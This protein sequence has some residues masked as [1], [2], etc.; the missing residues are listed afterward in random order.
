MVHYFLLGSIRDQN[1]FWIPPR[2]V[3]AKTTKEMEGNVVQAVKQL[4]HVLHLNPSNTYVNLLIGE[5]LAGAG[6]GDLAA[7]YLR[8]VAV[9]TL[10]W[11]YHHETQSW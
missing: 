8:K 7:P 5:Y 11:S 9:H 1:D 4:S 6:R 2:I 3:L 10:Q